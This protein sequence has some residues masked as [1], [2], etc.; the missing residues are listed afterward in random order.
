MIISIASGK[1]GS[2]KTKIAS[3]LAWVL[4]NGVQF[5]DCDVEAP[6]AHLFLKPNFKVTTAVSIPVP[7]IDRQQCSYCGECVQICKFNALIIIAQKNILTFPELCHGCG[8]CTLV[9]PAKAIKEVGREIGVINQGR[10][11]KIE[12]VQGELR[13]GEALAPPL[14]RAVKECINP[15]KTVIID[16]SPG[17][18]CP[19]VEAVNGSNFC[20]LV[21]EPTPFGFSDLVLAVEMV[22]ELHLPFGV[23][24][25][26][27]DIGDDTVLN[28]CHQENI[29]VLMQIP[30]R[31]EIAEAYSQG[32]L[33]LEILPEYKPQFL[34]LYEKIKE[35][36]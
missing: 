2:G 20:L 6:N 32:K 4:G 17:T 12:F 14:I 21:T 31:R 8:G 26:Q 3:N 11:R 28:Y 19:V 10:A 30:T 5:L 35:F 18:S 33:L 36:Q 34:D 29:P 9:C 16:A 22:R 27:C 1:G 15:E 25:N 24:I 23:V 7:E 13:I